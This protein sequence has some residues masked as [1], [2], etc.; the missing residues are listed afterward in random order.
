[1]MLAYNRGGG[2]PIFYLPL[3][4]PL[5]FWMPCPGSVTIRDDGPPEGAYVR[6]CRMLVRARLYSH[7]SLRRLRSDCGAYGTTN[8]A[9]CV[10][11]RR[12]SRTA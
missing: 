6:H 10:A 1:M 11:I 5:T 4:A 3:M 9:S 7:T 2:D 8:S 12:S